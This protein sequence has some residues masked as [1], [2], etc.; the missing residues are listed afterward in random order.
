M[1]AFICV[2]AAV[3]AKAQSQNTV[4]YIP[5]TQT[6]YLA[7]GVSCSTNGN[8]LTLSIYNA[9]G[10]PVTQQRLSLATDCTRGEFVNDDTHGGTHN[11]ECD[12][13]VNATCFCTGAK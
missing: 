3:S 6:C 4:V 9:V 2:V 10:V 1:F 5:E 12:T 7:S 11:V 8:L 13:T